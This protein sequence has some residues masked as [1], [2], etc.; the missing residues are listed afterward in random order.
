MFLIDKIV[1]AVGFESEAVHVKTT[2][3]ASTSHKNKDSEDR[4]N[5]CSFPSLVGILNYSVSTTMHDTVR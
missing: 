2:I 1:T 5:Q 3:S 4:K